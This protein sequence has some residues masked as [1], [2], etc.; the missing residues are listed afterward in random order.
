[1]V[2][3]KLLTASALALALV[4]VSSAGA[5]SK[6]LIVS[7]VS[8]WGAL[9]RQ[10][11][12]P[13]AKVV[14]LLTDPNADPHEHE[15]TVS[16][17]EN[18]ARASVVIVN[19]AGYDTWLSKLVAVGGHRG[20]VTIDVGRLMGVTAGQNPHL[21]YSPE[22]ALRF[23]TALSATLERSP[24]IYPDV[25]AR[26]KVL[27]GQLSALQHRVAMV[28][29]TCARVRVSATEDVATY[30]LVDAGL[31]VVT[32]EALRLAVGNGIDPSIATLA[33]ALDQLTHHPAFLI[34]NVQTSTP[35][36]EEMV[37][38]AVALH[39][40]VVK[41]TETMT[42]RSYPTWLS[43]VVGEIGRDLRV[44]GCLQ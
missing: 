40:P 26:S 33:T 18:V 15:A 42:G 37:T 8:Q 34:D 22:A 11:V 9:A 13:D 21:F 41:V 12:G 24:T 7:G 30:L 2:L 23:V 14:T 16:D 19:G 29:T 10:L 43:G 38:R 25:A 1:M 28:R 20:L 5:A 39:V 3:G 35:L 27:L 6:P 32:P 17:A 36:T 4:S 31:R 44:E